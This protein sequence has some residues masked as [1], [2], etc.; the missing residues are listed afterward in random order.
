MNNNQIEDEIRAAIKQGDIQLVKVLINADQTRLHMMTI[1][2][3]WLHVAAKY[4][5]LEIVKY[6]VTAGIDI[7][8]RGGIGGGGA[9]NQAASEGHLEVVKFLIS[10]GVEMDV[11]N[12]E[13]NPLF[14]A[15]CWGHVA[16]AKLL[17][18]SGIDIGAKNARKMDARAIA[19]ER[20]QTEIAALLGASVSAKV[21]KVDA[22]V[23]ESPFGVVND[24]MLVNLTG[25]VKKLKLEKYRDFILKIAQPS[26]ELIPTNSEIR[27]GCSKFGGS[28]DLPQGFTWPQ[29]E[30]GPYRFICQINLSEL[31]KGLVG[32]P[33]E[34][35]L[36]FFYAYDE[37]GETFWGDPNFI[38][39]FHFANAGEAQPVEPP[40]SVRLDS[41]H[42]I[43]FELGADV[44]S[45][46]CDAA[47]LEDWPMD[48][49]KEDAYWELRCQLHRCRR[50]L[51]G[52]PFNTTLA[53]D[54]TPGPE[55]C[56]L[57]TLGSDD[58]M[59]WS[60]HDGNWLVTFIEKDK[61]RNGDFSTIQADAG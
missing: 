42:G 28:P 30:L 21:G 8:R 3:S 19:I 15:I 49:S 10:C 16:I 7:N 13:V 55:W 14:N 40:K 32:L 60:W 53:Y 39:V 52:F 37:N 24:E 43:R 5:Q 58:K 59:N 9:L 17:I 46:P 41:S 4:G 33:S 48:E 18:E 6:L 51:L 45:W 29:H 56:S 26:I 12:P 34:G 11:S 38:R 50:Y 25:L 22:A 35:L 47:Q 27:M 2:G 31:P 23:L 44:P 57:L 36:S 20:K 1:F 61:I 54:P